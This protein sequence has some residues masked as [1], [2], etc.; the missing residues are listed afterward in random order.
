MRKHLVKKNAWQKV[1]MVAIYLCFVVAGIGCKNA[2][3]ENGEVAEKQDFP[4]AEFELP[5]WP[6]QNDSRE[7]YPSLVRW[8]VTFFDGEKV[9]TREVLP[10]ETQISLSEIEGVITGVVAQPITR[11]GDE[12]LAFFL[13]AGCIYPYE[14][15]I[16]WT[17]GWVASVANS[18]AR[19]VVYGEVIEV[20]DDD[21]DGDGGSTEIALGTGDAKAVLSQF[22]W[23]K[24]AATVRAKTVEDDFGKKIMY[25]P[26]I[27]DFARFA[28]YIKNSSSKAN[29]KLSTSDKYANHVQN[30]L[31]NI[32]YYRENV[33]VLK[34]KSASATVPRG[35]FS[36]VGE[37]N[38]KLSERTKKIEGNKMPL[39]QYIP[40]QDVM[41]ANQN[42]WLPSQK[43]M[44]FLIN[45]EEII[46]LYYSSSSKTN[47]VIITPID[48]NSLE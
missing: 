33:K 19:Q 18:V 47:L 42:V 9:H 11:H 48:Y 7:I 26:W 27:N 10:S 5:A 16:T 2:A 36:S 38:M 15:K 8:E 17:D 3:T 44:Y 14:R 22:D 31:E 35:E 29:S 40:Y 20:E 41:Y 45:E 4:L 32:K 12:E 39:A 28:S 43:N 23:Q 24:Y 6:P 37:L 13:S 46:Q 25:E 21:D 30:V 34:W 1:G